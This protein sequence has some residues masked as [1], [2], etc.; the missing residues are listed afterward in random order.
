MNQMIE[1][2][3]RG[4]SCWMDDLTR[5]MTT[6][7]ELARRVSEGVRGITSNPAIF[8]KAMAEGGDYDD[9]IAR[10]AAAGHSAQEIYEK[11]ITTD[12]RK[13]CDILRPVYDQSDR[14]D[15]FVSLEVSPHLAHATQATM[16]EAKRLW[17]RVDRPN[18]FIKVPATAAGVPAVEQLLFEGININI[19]LL[20]S[21]ASYEAVAEAYMRALE[22]RVRAGHPI[23]GVASVASFFLSRIDVLTDQ[24][25]KQRILPDGGI[26][27]EPDPEHLLG[28]AA[29]ANAKLAYQSFKRILESN[30]WQALTGKGARVQRMLWAST[31]TK[32]PDYYD[33]MYVEPLIGRLTINT[34]PRK[35]I[36]AL[37]DHG[38]VKNV[39]EEGVEEDV[40]EARRVMEDLERL[41]VRFEQV[42]AQ[43]EN[44]GVQKFIDP[45]DSL[46]K[47]LAEKRERFAEGSGGMKSASSG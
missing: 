11:L 41:G 5:R 6:S 26:K 29:V 45:F 42:T 10:A 16:D 1:L 38:V 2:A 40:P 22:R 17:A 36:A 39:V 19:T 24:L 18:L 28:K 3:A 44:E 23:E 15:G 47:R 35:T 4:Q 27:P 13:A 31:S 21:I 7:G 33:L 20:F 14:I 43:L 32:N 25:L 34:M 37:L 9:D 12:V 8:E 46:M 30:R